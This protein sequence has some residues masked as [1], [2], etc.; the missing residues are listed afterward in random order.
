MWT[1]TSFASHLDHR[2]QVP[3]LT[4]DH[5][6]L[7]CHRDGVPSIRA[8]GWGTDFRRRPCLAGRDGRWGSRGFPGKVG[9]L[10]SHEVGWCGERVEGLAGSCEEG[11]RRSGVR[12]PGVV[13]ARPWAATTRISGESALSRLVVMPSRAPWGLGRPAVFAE[14]MWATTG[15]N[16]DDAGWASRVSAPLFDRTTGTNP[17]GWMRHNAGATSG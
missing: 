1:T 4:V 12:D 11:G 3:V 8:E 7:S 16:P 17:A 14:R 2:G 10:R 9:Q 5:L 13:P 15:F 6:P